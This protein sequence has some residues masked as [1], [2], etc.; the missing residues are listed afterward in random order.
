[1]TY[2]L[3]RLRCAVTG[4]RNGTIKLHFTGRRRSG[5]SVRVRCDRCA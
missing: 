5:G 4:H 1:M 3:R 2:L